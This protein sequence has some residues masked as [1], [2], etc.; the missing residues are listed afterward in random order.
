MK[1]RQSAEKRR[2]ELLRVERQRD[3]ADRRKQPKE[4]GFLEGDPDA[5]E[6]LSTGAETPPDSLEPSSSGAEP[7]Q[8][9]PLTI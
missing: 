5:P 6:A 7:P 1:G 9:S 3:K 8:A 2:K 4:G